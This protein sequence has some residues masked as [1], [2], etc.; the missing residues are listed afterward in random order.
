VLY[1]QPCHLPVYRKEIQLSEATLKKYAGT[2]EP[3]RQFSVEF[4]LDSGQLWVQPSGQ[5]RSPI[6]AEKENFFFSKVVDGQVEFIP[7]ASGDIVSIVIYQGG[8]P[9]SG[10]KIK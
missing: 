4:I 7:D 2:Y 6:Y 10:K 1:H 8:H 9:M 5:P 3:G